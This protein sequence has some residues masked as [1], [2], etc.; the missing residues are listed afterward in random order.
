MQ[1]GNIIEKANK[2]GLNIGDGSTSLDNLRLIGSQVGLHDINS[3]ADAG[4]IES[5][6][7]QKLSDT[8]IVE[9]NN[10]QDVQGN[11]ESPIRN[12]SFGQ[13]EYDMAKKD[14]VYDKN[15]YKEKQNELDKKS[16]DLNQE[17]HKNWKEKK[18]GN[19][20]IKADGSNTVRKSKMDRVMDNL[21]Y[22]NAKKDAITN[23]ING[24]KANFYNATHP[25]ESAKDE[26]KNKA[27][28]AVKNVEKKAAAKGKALLSAAGKKVI[29]FIAAN[30]W[31]LMVLAGVILFILIL[32]AFAGIKFSSTG[33]YSA[34]CDFNSAR[35]FLAKCGTED[36]E[37]LTLE[38]YVVG[39]TFKL[40]NGKNYSDDVIKAIMIVV[41]TNALSYGNYNSAE[42]TLNL[43]DCELEYD[44]NIGEKMKYSYLSLY[45]QISNYL[46]VSSS[47]SGTISNMSESS[48]LK[49]DSEV[50]E[51]MSKLSG[52]YEDI[53]KSI[54]VGDENSV[55]EYRATLYV[56]DSRLLGMIDSGSVNK[57]NAVYG[58]GY[59]YDWFVG[60]RT[61]DS[62][63]TNSV[64]GGINGINELITTG[65]NYNI[66]V[67]LGVNDFQSNNANTYYNKYYELA[68]GMWKNHNIYI[69]SVGPVAPSLGNDGIN[70]FNSEMKNLINESNL[71]NL[72]YLDLNYNIET[73][74]DAGIHYSNSDY[75]NIYTSINSYLDNSLNG[76]YVIYNLDEHCTYYTVTDSDSYWWPIG[77]REATS[78]DIYGGEPTS[79]TI[80]S[81]FGPRTINGVSSNHGA[82][83]IAGVCNQ[84]V[85]IATKEG[86]VK[87]V[88]DTCDNNGYYG[89]SCGS[90]LGNYVILEH[91]DG[92]ESRYGHMYP[93]SITVKE[94]DT[95]KQ[96][97]KLGLVGNSGNS[98]G[99]HLHYEMRINN[100]K[101][102]PL[103]YVSATETR[104]TVSNNINIVAGTEEGGKQNV[105]KA[106]LNSGFSKNAVIGIM[107]N[108]NRESSFKTTAVEHKSGYTID[109]IY[110]APETKAAGFGLVQWSFG[111]RIKMINYAKSKGL[112]PT[113]LQ[114]QLEFLNYEIQNN[115]P[116]TKKY[117][118]GNYSAY[119]IALN[120]CL[121]FERPGNKKVKCP[122]R[123]NEYI[124]SYTKYVN[125]GCN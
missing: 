34:E 35:V 38:D 109:T 122:Q 18:E 13:K 43:D 123:V 85:V 60:N 5:V 53:L 80:T 82:I 20:P 4:K 62:E 3:L 91:S 12:N 118:F 83:D 46:Y 77:S 74:D 95:V 72:K 99:C 64:S 14:G 36:S 103:K 111:R 63:N 97:Q 54:Y 1:A 106:L 68:T 100:T 39:T 23:K 65:K 105:C 119:D 44:G 41:K 102:D 21:R 2:L 101:V 55:G 17:R 16:D 7:D 112:S 79:T 37:E 57:S 61:F 108:M 15:H 116:T 42:K 45:N 96:G 56:G 51:E 24:A 10:N 94:G 50:I 8:N 89:N 92:T 30:P 48:A 124:D 9:P 113:S 67:W 125:N 66:I 69:V 117:L 70:T 40:V 90:G 107:I 86:T 49:L 29:V 71:S 75:N 59:G 26:L 93:N 25:L 52:S 120:F 22:A 19:E 81:Q 78:G 58:V 98:T 76:D 6:L 31:I 114:A 104:T 115:Y 84:D 121:D 33:Y 87:T 47:Y 28:G 32:L 27:K 73:F 11:Q 110:N 88:S